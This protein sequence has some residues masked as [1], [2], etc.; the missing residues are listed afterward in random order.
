MPRRWTRSWPICAALRRGSRPDGR[1]SASARRSPSANPDPPP[2]ARSMPEM[3]LVLRHRD[4]KDLGTLSGYQ[5][6]G[7]WAQFRRAV[8]EMQPAEVLEVVK[9]SGLRGR[10]GAG[11]PT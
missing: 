4:V 8:T 10:G 6:A 2:M 1:P 3:H 7:G 5:A 11:F 9:A